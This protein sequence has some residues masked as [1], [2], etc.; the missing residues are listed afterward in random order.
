MAAVSLDVRMSYCVHTT[1]FIIAT[2]RRMGVC[3][4]R[5]RQMK[6]NL[7]Q[8]C[9]PPHAQKSSHFLPVV[10][11]ARACRFGATSVVGMG[12]NKIVLGCVVESVSLDSSDTK[13]QDGWP[14]VFSTAIAVCVHPPLPPF[15]PER[16][17]VTALCVRT[18]L[19]LNIHTMQQAS[20]PRLAGYSVG[21]LNDD[22]A[23]VTLHIIRTRHWSRCTHLYKRT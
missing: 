9:A 6:T 16:N 19:L 5:Y 8:H 12:S 20:Y 17:A 4:K 18:W 11:A 23:L 1:Q 10:V 21:Q 3:A 2:T 14:W 22:M 15:Q 13:T 7:S